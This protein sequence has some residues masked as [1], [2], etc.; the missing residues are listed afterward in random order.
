MEK[1]FFVKSRS[2]VTALEYGLIAALVLLIILGATELFGSRIS[3]VFTSVHTTLL[4]SNLTDYKGPGD[5]MAPPSG[6]ALSYGAGSGIQVDRAV[7]DMDCQPVDSPTSAIYSGD[8]LYSAQ[9]NCSVNNQNFTATVYKNGWIATL[10]N[11]SDLESMGMGGQ[12]IVGS[13]AVGDE[14]AQQMQFGHGAA[15]G[16]QFICTYN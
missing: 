1:T 14:F 10:P 7:D 2:A 8:Q 6:G 16:N 9:L 13:G 15:Q 12:C 5:G 3:S 11:A 4:S